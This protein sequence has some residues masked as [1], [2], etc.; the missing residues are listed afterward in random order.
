LGGS[1]EP[2]PPASVTS[3]PVIARTPNAFAA[4]A[5]SSEP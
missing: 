3:A 5:N 1:V 2:T 4:Y